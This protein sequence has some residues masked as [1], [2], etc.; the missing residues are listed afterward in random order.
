MVGKLI[1]AAILDTLLSSVLPVA[2]IFVM[3]YLA[4]RRSGFSQPDAASI[5]KF[6]AQIS[7]PAIIVNI[8]ITTDVA[9]P[10]RRYRLYLI[11]I[12]GLCYR[13]LHH[14]VWFGWFHTRYA[15]LQHPQPCA[16][17]LSDH[18]IRLRPGNVD[19]RSQHHHDRYHHF[20]RYH[21]HS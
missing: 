16:V 14:L 11:N 20:H 15:A 6:I 3:G 13:F 2:L 18:T 10:T 17:R 4:G 1:V 12:D 5:F 7:A 9:S 8:V 19:P 21:H